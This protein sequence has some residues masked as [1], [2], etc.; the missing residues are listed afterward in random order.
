MQADINLG[1]IVH[2]TLD[3]LKIIVAV[4]VILFPTRQNNRESLAFE[5]VLTR[6]G[7][8]PGQI[9]FF[10]AVSRSSRIGS[11]MPWIKRDDR[12]GNSIADGSAS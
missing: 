2:H 7:D 12:R 1:S 8:L 3:T 10:Q 11:S 5:P 6:N 4:N 9:S